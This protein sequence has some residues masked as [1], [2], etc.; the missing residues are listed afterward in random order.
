MWKK[1]IGKGAKTD[2]FPTGVNCH[3]SKNSI[4]A[5]LTPTNRN[6]YGLVIQM[7][8]FIYNLLFTNLFE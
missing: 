8:R 2:I 6:S 3:I 1:G 5:Y 7:N 4:C